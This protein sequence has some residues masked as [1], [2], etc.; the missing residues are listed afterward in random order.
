[1]PFHSTDIEKFWRQ[2]MD[3]CRQTVAGPDMAYQAYVM[4]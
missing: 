2:L 3:A 4:L 1:M